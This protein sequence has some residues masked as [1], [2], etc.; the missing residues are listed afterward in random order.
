MRGLKFAML[1]GTVLFVAATA[2]PAWAQRPAAWDTRM[3]STAP[4]SAP[5]DPQEDKGATQSNDAPPVQ[6]GKAV[7]PVGNKKNDKIRPN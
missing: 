4:A 3:R 6:P 1:G 7:G 5:A 2:W